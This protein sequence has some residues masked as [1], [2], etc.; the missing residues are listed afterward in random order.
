VKRDSYRLL[1]CGGRRFGST[2]SER[3]LVRVTLD[4]YLNDNLVIITGGATGADAV[5][6]SWARAQQ[7]PLV[8]VP[9]RWRVLGRAAGPTRNQFMLDWLE[10]VEVVAFPGGDGT[11]DMVTRARAA[12]VPVNE[13]TW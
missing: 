8:V 10:P 7:V 2:R 5:A 11:A 1:V 13:V 4:D 3:D 9:A 6:E 12:G